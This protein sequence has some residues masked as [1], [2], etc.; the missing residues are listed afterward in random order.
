VTSS[1]ARTLRLDPGTGGS[2]FVEEYYGDL[3]SGI[4]TGNMFANTVRADD[5]DTAEGLSW[6]VTVPA[7]GSVTISYS[8]ALLLTQQ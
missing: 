6:Q 2:A 7:N 3:W 1:G 4:A 5:H 8:T